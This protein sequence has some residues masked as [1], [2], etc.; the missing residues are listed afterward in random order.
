MEKLSSPLLKIPYMETVITDTHFG[1][2]SFLYTYIHIYILKL[3][4][5]IYLLN[6]PNLFIYLVA[7]DRMGRMLSFVAR[8]RADTS[9]SSYPII[10]GI[11]VDEH[12]AL[13]LNTQNGDVKTVGVNTAYVC[14]ATHDPE[15]CSSKTPLSFTDISCM[16]LSGKDETTYSFASWTGN[17]V[18]YVN[19]I[20]KGVFTSIPYGPVSG[21]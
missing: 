2:I 3:F 1:I 20:V 14:T 13:L 15:V 6:L 18:P 9:D 7:R 10:R 11:G 5:L 4:Y 12:T 16:R 21:N 17:G 8:L 19:N